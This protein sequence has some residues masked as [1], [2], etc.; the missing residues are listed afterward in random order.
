MFHEKK[1]R[2]AI[3]IWKENW[4]LHLMASWYYLLRQCQLLTVY[5]LWHLN[6]CALC[7][8][9]N[10][11][12]FCCMVNETKIT[13]LTKNLTSFSSKNDSTMKKYVL[14]SRF[15]R[16][17]DERGKLPLS[18]NAKTCRVSF[19]FTDFQSLSIYVTS[20]GVEASNP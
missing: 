15:L 3:Q 2:T 11:T 8:Q 14:N 17:W 16:C 7:P 9:K 1:N 5:L 18:L 12:I 13:I 10:Y 19:Y 4:H 20:L 6:G